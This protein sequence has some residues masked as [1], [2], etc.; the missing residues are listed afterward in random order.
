MKNALYA[1]L[2]E[3]KGLEAIV[4][5]SGDPVKCETMKKVKTPKGFIEYKDIRQLV[6]ESL[7][8][9]AEMPSLILG[10]YDEP[11]L[12][13]NFKEL[14]QSS[15]SEPALEGIDFVYVKEDRSSNYDF[16]ALR[17]ELTTPPM[18]SKKKI[19]LLDSPYIYNAKRGNATPKAGKEDY[20]EKLEKL[21]SMLQ[22][23]SLLVIMEKK[24]DKRR[25]KMY[26][27]VTEAGGKLL[28]LP[29]QDDKVLESF[30]DT[31]CK[32]HGVS[33]TKEARDMLVSSFG[34]EGMYKIE[35]ECIKLSLYV[36]ALNRKQIGR[37]DV[38]KVSGTGLS[39]EIFDLTDAMSEKDADKALKILGNLQKA[40][41]PYTLI[42]FMIARQIRNL[43]ACKDGG[44]KE[45]LKAD[46]GLHPFVIY[47]LLPAAQKFSLE[48]LKDIYKAC[49][50][51]DFLSKR[52]YYTESDSKLEL[53]ILKACQSPA[54]DKS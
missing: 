37:E 15:F 47:K 52:G 29:K 51:I 46:M 33:L 6:N 53:L 39:E 26:K 2:G 3:N 11:F 41:E 34:E 16:D 43:L 25:K 20:A 13:D 35:S 14:L 27:T 22:P 42:L 19:L 44:D 38:L 24:L 1:S 4:K 8:G 17:N 40:G 49:F 48:E 45:S 28:F 50:E 23:W 12:F 54:S 30:A 18:L 31:V 5:K 9:E 10:E 32:K 36:G 21:Y 7:A